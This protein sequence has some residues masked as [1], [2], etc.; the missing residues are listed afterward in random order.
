MT[1]QVIRLDWRLFVGYAGISAAPV[2]AGPRAVL[3]VV[4]GGCVLQRGLSRELLQLRDGPT[5]SRPRTSAGPPAARA[6][7]APATHAYEPDDRGVDGQDADHAGSALDFLVD[8]LEQVGTPNLFPVLG[9]EVTESEHI[10]L[11]MPHQFCCLGEPL[12]K[13]ASQIV[14]ASLDLGHL[15]LGEYRAQRRGHDV[16]MGLGHALEQVPGEVHLPAAALQHPADRVGEAHVGVA[17]H[18]IDP[19]E[20]ALLMLRRS[21][22]LWRAEELTPEALAFAVAH[23]DAEQLMV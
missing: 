11:G 6:R 13:R 4:S 8:A 14:P 19:R 7:P 18:E 12:H 20:A 16:L 22:L 17:D 1:C 21:P 3:V 10:L 2:V 9:R 15:L 23:L 5:C